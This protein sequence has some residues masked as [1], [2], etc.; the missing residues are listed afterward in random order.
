MSKNYER[1]N[2]V[3]SSYKYLKQA[4]SIKDTVFSN[5]KH[6]IMYG[7]NFAE[8]DRQQEIKRNNDL[9]YKN[10]EKLVQL[11]IIFLGIISFI[12]LFLLLSYSIIVDERWVSFLGILGF[13]FLFEFINLI[14]HPFLDELLNHKQIFVF[15]GMVIIGS[16]L[17]PFHHKLEGWI[18]PKLTEKNKAIRIKNAKKTLEQY[19]DK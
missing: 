13:L 10:R 8:K 1:I 17:V 12:M 16:I 9:K 18:I 4:C 15:F 3:D 11:I 6:R 19:E 2:N 7:I 5:E 14:I